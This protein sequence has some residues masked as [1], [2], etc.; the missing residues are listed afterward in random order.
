[1]IHSEL[2]FETI[3]RNPRV[4]NGALLTS[5]AWLG[6]ALSI[7]LLDIVDARLFFLYV[8]ASVGVLLCMRW[9]TVGLYCIAF[10][11]PFL[12]LQIVVGPVNAP[13][14]DILAVI[15]IFACIGRIVFSFLENK[16]SVHGVDWWG[17]PF[18][19]AWIAVGI[20]SALFTDEIPP[21]LYYVLRTMSFFYVA[22]V[23]VPLNTIRTRQI[24]HR[25]LYSMVAVGGVVAVYG[26]YG[27]ALSF[28]DPNIPRRVTPVDI[29]GINPLGANHNLI[30]EVMLATIPIALY[31]MVMEKDT[32][33]QKIIAV[34][35]A[36]LI[37]AALLTFSRTAWLALGVEIIVLIVMQYRHRMKEVLRYGFLI[38]VVLLPVIVYMFYFSFASD[39]VE[40]SNENRL[41]LNDVA[42]EMFTDRPLIGSG[43]G[44]FIHR[45]GLNTVYTSEYGDPI[46]AHGFIQ[47]VGSELG[48]LGVLLYSGMLVYAVY[49][50]VQAFYQVQKKEMARYL[51]LA[52]LMML[53][54]SIFAQLFQTSYYSAKL[55]LPL[56]VAIAASHLLTEKYKEK[57]L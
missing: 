12:N 53:S 24:L 6:I 32:L 15:A 33:R 37:A 48:I 35:I 30:S 51:L 52:M 22:Y 38:G 4:R 9:P 47:K 3:R 16:E 10:T 43:P 8:A 7:L 17:V 5:V 36:G 23:F 49:T 26:F 40:S 44:T 14:V 31:L 50:V 29:F 56:G 20:L 42:L 41:L 28:V 39:I 13:I 27:L 45:L 18:C 19:V 11:Y 55:W 21:S 34:G 1:M 2:L 25:V 54:G 57:I 46:D